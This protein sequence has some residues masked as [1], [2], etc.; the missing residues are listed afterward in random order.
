MNKCSMIY[1]F[2]D[3]VDA[4]SAASGKSKE[5][6]A[7]LMGCERKVLYARGGTMHAVYLARFCAVT[8]VSA[9]YL[10]GLTEG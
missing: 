4:A 9:D 2:W 3:R 10:L 6:I 5:Q 8:G 1:G 7:R